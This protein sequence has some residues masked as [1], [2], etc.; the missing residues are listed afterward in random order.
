MGWDPKFISKF[1]GL[2]ME[3]W[4]IIYQI[5]STHYPKTDGVSEILNPI[6]EKYLSCYFSLHRTIWVSCRRPQNFPTNWLKEKICMR[7]RLKWVL[8]VILGTL[9]MK[10]P[11]ESPIESV[12]DPNTRI[13]VALKDATIIHHIYK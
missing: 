2:L 7:I 3:R 1:W 9:D 4:D 12:T 10:F 13:N 11:T 6:L 5:Y 8:V